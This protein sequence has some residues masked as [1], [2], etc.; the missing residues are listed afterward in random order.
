V[1]KALDSSKAIGDSVESVIINRESG[2]EYVGDS[3][4]TWYDA[5]TVECLSP[6]HERPF[7]G[8]PLV[9]KGSWIEIKGACVVRSNG[10]HQCAGHWYIKRPAHESL[11]EAGSFYLL[12]VYAPHDGTPILRSVIIPASLLD[13]EL[14]GRWYDVNA[15]DRADREV[16]QLSWPIVIDRRN[17][18]GSPE[19]D[20]HA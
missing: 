4:A 12:A 19:V 20:P 11:L 16:A 18:P 7:L 8:V 15:D 6:S 10:T 9:E 13:E 3:V 5:R 2:L 14:A 17:V 1:S